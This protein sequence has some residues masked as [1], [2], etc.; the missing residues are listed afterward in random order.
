M[1][2]KLVAQLKISPETYD[3]VFKNNLMSHVTRSVA[4]QQ[5]T[6]YLTSSRCH[7]IFE[8]HQKLVSVLVARIA[9]SV[10]FTKTFNLQKLLVFECVGMV[11]LYE[12][13]SFSVHD[14]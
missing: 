2:R 12:N 10:L 6:F 11:R 1:R 5:K 14:C 8:S 4:I 9:P 7:M 13:V 3:S